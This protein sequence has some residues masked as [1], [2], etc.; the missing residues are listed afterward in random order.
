MAPISLQTLPILLLIS[1]LALHLQVA[2]SP[3]PDRSMMH[4]PDAKQASKYLTLTESQI[5][6]TT[7]T[8]NP[9]HHETS[10]SVLVLDAELKPTRVVQEDNNTTKRRRQVSIAGP[11]Q[12]LAA[13]T[14]DPA[15]VIN[16]GDNNPSSNKSD[17]QGGGGGGSGGGS[18]LTKDQHIQIGLGIGLGVPSAIAG[19]I[20][21]F[22]FIHWRNCRGR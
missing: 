17:D 4:P 13:G 7:T 9:P 11:N 5:P 22:N 18:G 10:F 3:I 21:I 19:M 8:D 12:T 1:A 14:G 15:V 20:S 6:A 2:G 16:N